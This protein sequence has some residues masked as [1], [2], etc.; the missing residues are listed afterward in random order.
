MKYIAKAQ[1]FKNGF[2]GNTYAGS[3]TKKGLVERKSIKEQNCKSHK[4]VLGDWEELDSEAKKNIVIMKEGK[5][6][7][8]P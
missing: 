1:M 5:I 2:I 7:I 3:N 4:V 8:A 6:Y